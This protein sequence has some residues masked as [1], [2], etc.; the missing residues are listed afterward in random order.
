MEAEATAQI[1]ELTLEEKLETRNIQVDVLLSQNKLNEFINIVNEQLKRMRDEI[2]IKD[3]A[4]LAHLQGVIK[5][6]GLD[7]ETSIFDW[8]KMAV[9]TKPST[10][11]AASTPPAA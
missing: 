5:S 8:T 7:I 6:K 9:S 1:F 4:L 2:V 10:L 3:Q 11:P